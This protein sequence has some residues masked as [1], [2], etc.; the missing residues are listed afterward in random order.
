MTLII[1]SDEILDLCNK[2]KSEKFICVD[3]EFIREKYYHPKLCLIQ[4]GDSKGNGWAIDPLIKNINLQ[5]LYELFLNVKI[6]KVFHSPRQDFEIIFNI[7]N[8]I[9]KPIFD[10]QSA[11]MACGFG[12]SASYESLVNNIVNIN[13]DKSARFTDWQVRPLSKK[14]ID[15]A[16]S[17]VTHLSK[18]YT[19]LC[20]EM[21]KNNRLDWI[22]EE[23]HKFFDLSIYVTEPANAWKRIKFFSSNKITMS[24]FKEIA[25][26]REELA[27]S[28][29]VPRNKIMRDDIIIKLAKNPPKDIAELDKLRGMNLKYMNSSH[30][31]LI[32][33]SIETGKKNNN[34][35]WLNNNVKNN[36]VSKAVIDIL[37]IIL[38]S[39]AEKYNISPLLIANREDI[40]HIAQGKKDVKALKGWRYEIFGSS[41]LKLIEGSLT[42]TVKDGSV[43]IE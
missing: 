42:L 4:I 37:K 6:L 18:I 28:L 10:T 25:Q 35:D 14:Q 34:T 40:K 23:I 17:D 36:N 13:L 33:K 2:L 39:C 1:Q 41:A 30:K 19:Y 8:K 15:Y 3:T 38:L 26:I 24:V 5:P 11:A 22:K 7:L 21:I 27:K 31:T 20:E 43:I 12:D 9:P 32:L 16:I 29:N